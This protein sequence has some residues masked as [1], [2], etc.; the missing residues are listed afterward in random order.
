[1]HP[2]NGFT[3]NRKERDNEPDTRQTLEAM[4]ATTIHATQT[5]KRGNYELHNWQNIRQ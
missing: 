3:N 1:M 4:E 2:V 5:H